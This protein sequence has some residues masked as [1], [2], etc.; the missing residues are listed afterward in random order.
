MTPRFDLDL[1]PLPDAIALLR[2]LIGPALS[3]PD[4]ARRWLDTERACLV[5]I[6]RHPAGHGW[7]AHTVQL[8]TI[9]YRYLDGGHFADA[10]IIHGHARDAARQDGD[11]AGQAQA[12]TG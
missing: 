11:P 7:P 6:A 4:V 2:N 9:L 3:N 5:A 8:S 12:L 1:L 10:L